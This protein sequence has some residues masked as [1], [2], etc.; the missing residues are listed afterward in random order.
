MTNIALI[1]AALALLVGGALLLRAGLRGRRVDDAPLC[2]ACG[3]ELTGLP[4]GSNCPECG[5]DV[6]RPANVRVGHRRRRPGAVL[7]GVALLLVPPIVGGTLVSGIDPTPYKPAWWLMRELDARDSA[8]VSAAL[9]ELSWRQTAGKLSKASADGLFDR[10]LAR[11]AD[12]SKPWDPAWGGV[13]E[14]A[15]A[16]GTLDDVRWSRY[17]RQV[18]DFKLEAR[19]RVRQG[20][21]LPV[22]LTINDARLGPTASFVAWYEWST[23]RIGGTAFAPAK[24]GLGQGWIVVRDHG[25]NRTIDQSD[26][27]DITA[28]VP[29][30]ADD[31]GGHGSLLDRPLHRPILA[32]DPTIAGAGNGAGKCGSPRDHPAARRTGGVCHQ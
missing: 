23:V 14:I 11:Q 30:G 20:D 13:L 32:V 28:R 21:P 17:A 18:F 29:P 4:A 2:R 26:G 8:T 25:S 27:S 6:G 5:A 12:T 15:R 22:E 7:L 24:L 31:G 19:P 16:A 10:A 3:F 1:L 9:G